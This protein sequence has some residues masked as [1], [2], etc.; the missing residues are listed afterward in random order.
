MDGLYLY[1]HLLHRL[2]IVIR[3]ICIFVHY[4][5]T[6]KIGP[7]VLHYLKGLVEICSEVVFVSNCELPP[8]E[9]NKVSPIVSVILSRE[10]KGMDFGAWRHAID[11]VG[12]SHLASYDELILA[13][14]SCY[15]P[16]FAFTDMFNTMNST[17]ADFWGV[18]EH[19]A[20][21]TRSG[22][23][24]A[25]LQSYFLVFTKRV[26]LSEI[27]RNFWQEV[28]TEDTDYNTVIGNYESKLTPTLNNAGFTHKAYIN[29]SACTGD[30]GGNWNNP[31]YVN[32]TIWS[33]RKL[34][35]NK[36]PFLKRKA[37]SFHFERVA[38]LIRTG[39]GRKVTKA[40]YV[41]TFFWRKCIEDSDSTYP[42]EIICKEIQSEHGDHWINSSQIGK[43][44]MFHANTPYRM[45]KGF[46][47]TVAKLKQQG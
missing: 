15:A 42:I 16:M 3:R 33:W 21:L 9:Q 43:R 7:S 40:A 1:S 25:H 26:I 31:L 18:T 8:A 22:D 13:N 11:H 34:L 36:S 44:M 38:R 29:H 32:R 35:Q 39:Y 10:N 23:L 5:R 19:P 4:D 2:V 6:N 12:W 47:K 30:S 27:F 41:H 45:Y 37:I 24:E 28:S 14:D 20:A 17:E 46:T